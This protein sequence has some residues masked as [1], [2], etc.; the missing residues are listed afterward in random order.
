MKADFHETMYERRLKLFDGAITDL[1]PACLDPMLLPY[2]YI[3]DIAWERSMVRGR[4]TCPDCPAPEVGRGRL[5]GARRGGGARIWGKS[6]DLSTYSCPV[7]GAG[8]WSPDFA[9]SWPS[10]RQKQKQ[11]SSILGLC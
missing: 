6:G 8:S 9:F 1:I 2:S 7:L 11:P 5:G 10:R 4:F 3:T